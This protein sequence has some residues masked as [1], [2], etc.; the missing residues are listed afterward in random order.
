[1]TTVFQEVCERIQGEMPELERVVQRALGAWSRAQQTR[2][3][4]AYLDSVALNLHAFYSGLKRLF[5]LI[6]RHVDR[7]LPGGDTRHRDLLY[8]MGSDLPEARPAVVSQET[9]H[10]LDEF[11]RFRHVVLRV[12]S[13][14]LAPEK[15]A[16]V[17]SSLPA[18]WATLR[19]ELVAFADF[20][21]ALGR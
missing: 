13:V 1:V 16:G 3:E 2:E 20:L 17:M 11:R 6:A 18:V 10:A 15:L 19:A 9:V 7:R 14:T 21:E 12:Y 4:Y 5:K 8:Q